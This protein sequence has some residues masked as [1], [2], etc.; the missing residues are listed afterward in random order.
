MQNV[1]IWTVGRQPHG[2]K[3]VHDKIN[4][5]QLRRREEAWVLN[6]AVDGRDSGIPQHGYVCRQLE[7]KAD[8]CEPKESLLQGEHYASYLQE[9]SDRVVDTPAPCDSFDNRREVVVK[10]DNR[11]GFLGDLGP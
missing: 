7:L 8:H 3:D 10:Q 1:L 2:T 11:R 6:S 4:P 5:K 9:A